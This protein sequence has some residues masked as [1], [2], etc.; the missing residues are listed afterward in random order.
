M[1]ASALT[2]PPCESSLPFDPNSGETRERVAR[3]PCAIPA[4]PGAPE[5]FPA[6]D[7][8]ATAISLDTARMLETLLGNL[9]GMVY[10]C[11]SDEH[12]TMEFVSEG[13]ERL[14]GYRPRDLLM[15]D[16]ISYELLTHEDDRAR[17]REE[18]QAGLARQRR[19]DL[20]YRIV[21]ADGRIVWVWERGV[22][23]YDAKGALIAIE[24]IVQDISERKEAERRYRDL[25][26]HAVEGI[27]RTT[28]DGRFLDANPALARIYGF[29]SPH[30]LMAELRDIRGQLYVD[31]SRREEFMRLIKVRGSISGFE[32]QIYRRDGQVIWVAENARAVTDEAGR[33]VCYEGTVQDITERK[34]YEARI[35]RAANYDALT[36]LANRVLLD[37]RLEQAILSAASYGTR[38]AVVFV[39]LDHFKQINDTLG[40]EAG[41]EL[42]R[43][44][45]QRLKASVR[46]TDTVARLG[47]D[48]FVLLINNQGDPP[49]IAVLLE[50][51]LADICRPWRIGQAEF[52]ITCSLGVALY[53][54][55]GVTA[56][57]LLRHADSAM[58]R[59][60][61][62]GRNNFQF[63]TPEINSLISERQ[64]L[65]SR[66]RQAFAQGRFS[67]CYQPR[68][69]MATR[70]IVGAEA[71]IRWPDEPRVAPARFVAVAEEIG[72]SVPLGRWV[73]ERAC[74]QARSW[75]AAG[76]P[77]VIVSV[78]VSERQFRQDDFV[79]SVAEVLAA[80]GLDPARLEI[81]LTESAVTHDVER[82]MV[83]LGKLAR[84]G[85]R[86]TLDDFGTGCTNLSALK[87]LPLHR[88]KM[89]GSFVRGIGTD[90]DDSAIVRSIVALGHNLGLK[91]VAEGVESEGQVAFLRA[92]GCDELQGYY[93]GVPMSGE[94]FAARL[95]GA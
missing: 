75:D 69:D 73:L 89:D 45:A 46:E 82:F 13:C 49:S 87:R 86:L 29:D 67:L 56:E 68:V 5:D 16:R 2:T 32:S 77:P 51:M 50:R 76:L 42:L 57:T 91:V 64:E 28:P 19:F 4:A 14:T 66:L 88:L 52:K 92:S 61:G 95:R 3:R 94:S 15:N 31:P 8:S 36:G 53:P 80:S 44:M 65:E 37:D 10:R 6:L 18:V 34:A 33:L 39:D 38:L 7:A 20:E 47:G 85:V 9:D 48:E 55:D 41:D 78:N 11:R 40:H 79:E 74:A 59:A 60:K 30:A 25:F 24:G 17:V 84:L 93:F 83:L 72:L 35:E 22:G 43:A 27:F 90:M 58:Y 71:L 63:F 21:R 12:W 54:D 26:E 62:K 81:E 70:R 23:I 1:K